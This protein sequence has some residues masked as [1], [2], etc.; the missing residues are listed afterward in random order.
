[1]E[2]RWPLSCQ[3]C[4]NIQSLEEILNWM[5]WYPAIWTFKNNRIYSTCDYGWFK[6]MCGFSVPV[7]TG[8]NIGVWTVGEVR[9]IYGAEF[10]DG[11]GDS[12]VKLGNAPVRDDVTIWTTQTI[13]DWTDTEITVLVVRGSL[14]E[15]PAWIY[16]NNFRWSKANCRGFQI[17]LFEPPPP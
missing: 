9:Y 13:L 5:K 4:N 17:D 1:M 7:V 15:G 10:L 14:P 2:I 8:T 3:Q 12:W 16:V 6:M 11:S